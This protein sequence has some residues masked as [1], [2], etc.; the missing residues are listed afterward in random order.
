MNP[1]SG[2]RQGQK[3]LDLKN[4]TL[5]FEMEP[6][7]EFQDS[8][9]SSKNQSSGQ[10]TIVNTRIFNLIDNESKREALGLIQTT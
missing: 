1:L 5:Q 10:G 9:S 8:K 2:S 4:K 7:I 6:N 3:L